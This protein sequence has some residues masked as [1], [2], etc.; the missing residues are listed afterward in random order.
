MIQTQLALLRRELWEHRAIYVAPLVLVLLVTLTSITGQVSISSLEEEVNLAILGTMNMSENERAMAITGVM[1]GISWLFFLTMIVLSYFYAIDALYAERKDKSILFWRSL[2]VTDSET[3]VSKLL[4][5]ALVIPA[6]TFVGIV[7]T[8]ILVL[9]VSSVWVG[10]RG[11]DAWSLIWGSA[12]LLQNWAATLIGV[13]LLP[14]WS[15]PFIGWFL[16]VSAFAKRSPFLLGGLPLVVLP[17][18]EKILLGTNVF[19]EMLFD[20]LPFNLPLIRDMPSLENGEVDEE[21]LMELAESGVNVLE[22]VDL[23]RFFGSASVWIGVLV[24][25]LFCAAAVYVRRYRDDS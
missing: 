6:V 3:V 16:F 15:S 8:H 2:P 13:L 25:A 1:L 19:A 5:A 24:C 4:T 17:M 22:F 14:I 18:L 23:G 7:V 21:D 10:M 20:R 9:L 12:P 11:V